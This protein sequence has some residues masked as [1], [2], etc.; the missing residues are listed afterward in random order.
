M[1]RAAAI[2]LACATL[3]KA[4]A[5]ARVEVCDLFRNLAGWDGK[6]VVIDAVIQPVPVQP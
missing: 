1:K 5:P 3:A 6:M 4:Q 2:A